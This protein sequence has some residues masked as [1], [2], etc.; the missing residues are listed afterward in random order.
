M[1]AVDS[2]E[3]TSKRQKTHDISLNM[4]QV[5]KNRNFLCP[6]FSTNY[7]I[8]LLLLQFTEMKSI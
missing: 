6:F 4:Q 1:Q 2:Y 8:W 3:D 7:S 5:S